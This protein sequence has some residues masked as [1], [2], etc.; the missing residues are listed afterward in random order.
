MTVK[1]YFKIVYYKADKGNSLNSSQGN[2]KAIQSKEIKGYFKMIPG[3]LKD[4]ST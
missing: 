1:R 2:Y 3:I 4:I